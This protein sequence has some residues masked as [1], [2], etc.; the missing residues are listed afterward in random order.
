MRK[1]TENKIGLGE[2]GVLA[3]D[4]RDVPT[5]YAGALPPLRI[6]GCEAELHVRMS[7]DKHAQLT[8]RVTA[9]AQNTDRKFMHKECITLQKFSVNLFCGLSVSGFCLLLR[10]AGECLEPPYTSIARQPRA[11][12]DQNRIVTADRSQYVRP[13][14]TV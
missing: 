11:A 14:F 4:E 1:S 6:C 5:A 2:W 7:R 10:L 8:S 13:S 12:Y 3:G 9:R